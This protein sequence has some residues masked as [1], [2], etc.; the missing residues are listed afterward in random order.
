MPLSRIDKEFVFPLINQI[1]AKAMRVDRAFGNLLLLIKTQGH[2]VKATKKPPIL[3]EN[4]AQTIAVDQQHFAGFEGNS[5]N[6]LARWLE[7]DFADVVRTGRG[8]SKGEAILAGLKPLHLDVVK[9]RH[10]THAK[11]Y[12]TSKFLYS[13][14]RT[15]PALLESFQQF[16]GIGS[17]DD[18][19][20]GSD[21]DLETLF[22]LRLLDQYEFDRH[23][24]RDDEYLTPL[25]RG[26]TAIFINDLQRVM[27]YQNYMPRR[28]L[29][30][31]LQTLTGFHL[32]LS[33][34][35]MF[36]VVNGTVEKGA[37]CIGSCKY[38]P[39]STDPVPDCPYPPDIFVDL[40]EQKSLSYVLAQAKVRKHYSEMSR[41]I[42][43]HIRVKKLDE[44]RT[45]LIE[46]GITDAGN[47]PR[48]LTGLLALEKHPRIETFF[49]G[50]IDDLLTPE[51]DEER[52]KQLEG[53]AKLGMG[54]LDTYVEMVYSLRQKYH[55]R[56][57][58]EMLDAFCGKNKD[59]GFLRVGKGRAGRRYYLGNELLET[60]V[61]L[62]VI[63]FHPKRGFY[64]RGI[65][66]ADFVTWLKNRYGILTDE[67]G[68]P[69]EGVEMTEAM[70]QNYEALRTRL[71]QLGFY[72]DV[73][74]ASNSQVIQPRFSVKGSRS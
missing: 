15:S 28:E 58:R 74:D 7:S 45:R 13:V 43:N 55:L 6:V 68:E 46:R 5:V 8:G 35:R 54:A 33:T 73:S 64:T 60:F 22:L 11:D 72:T 30:R 63:D 59:S 41:Y 70:H 66:V 17:R 61:Q 19:Y 23:S 21:L 32:A 24:L 38:N 52:N 9:L 25:C 29:I 1:D 47:L 44:F 20:D 37:V 57:H 31:Y 53:I 36:R 39:Q 18:H 56:Y 40:S 34:L 2:P 51:P 42:K 14:I 12:G 69:V 26:E 62:A 48:T 50:R 71:R 16:F 3:I 67:Y 4:L 65:T 27:L 49:E 10:P